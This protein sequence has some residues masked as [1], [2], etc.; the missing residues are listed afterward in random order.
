LDIHIDMPAYPV[1]KNL[2][3][4][5][6][7]DDFQ[8][9]GYK[10]Y[11]DPNYIPAVPPAYEE[12]APGFSQ[13]ARVYQDYS[14]LWNELLP[15]MDY[16]Q[17]VHHNPDQ[18]LDGEFVGMQASFA[19]PD[20]VGMLLA[21]Q[22][23]EE[24]IE[25]ENK[26]LPVR[27]RMSLEEL[28]QAHIQEQLMDT[29]KMNQ[30][31]AEAARLRA[32][33][34][35]EMEV[36]QYIQ[37]LTEQQM[38]MGNSQQHGL[39]QNAIL[40]YFGVATPEPATAADIPSAADIGAAIPPPPTAADIGAAVA[41]AL[42]PLLAGGAPLG[43]GGGGGGG[44]APPPG[45]G[46][47]GAPVGPPPVGGGGIPPPP[48]MPAGLLTGGGGPPG[49]GAPAGGMAALL[50]SI[51]GGRPTLRSVTSTS[52][53]TPA[54]A[55]SGGVASFAAQAAAALG[56]LR[57]ASNRTIAAPPATSTIAQQAAAAGLSGLRPTPPK[58][59]PPPPYDPLTDPSNPL[60]AAL[61]ARR[62]GI[63]P[64]TSPVSPTGLSFAPPTGPGISAVA[65][66]AGDSVGTSLAGPS[67]AA[68]SA[69]TTQVGARMD[70]NDV[71]TSLT[72]ITQSQIT[73]INKA[74]DVNKLPPYT[75]FRVSGTPNPEYAVR[76]PDGL[77]GG[78][79]KV[80]SLSN[81]LAWARG[82]E[83]LRPVSQYRKPNMGD[84]PTP[85][86]IDTKITEGYSR[87]KAGRKPKT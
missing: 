79:K 76:I 64:P 3:V 2:Q 65:P 51:A 71:R 41:A 15:Q 82:D 20:F 16:H 24:H 75:T 30:I 47:G 55:P 46:G 84:Q 44:G 61:A 83:N 50:A 69:A 1:L 74:S 54:P 80:V 10:G 17:F 28:I 38:F 62:G 86:F 5:G 22:M 57:P 48:P 42:A 70:A 34:A 78:N 31:K 40:Q 60:A 85:K 63:S 59:P 4:T 13:G 21:Q 27:D 26:T 73:N 43:G 81:F 14:P 53:S 36:R 68:A 25:H 6:K 49:G 8:L 67:S 77:L 66:P 58:S 45:G 33:G 87:G 35:S 72:T 11:R 23:Q 52:T 9:G 56:G 32:E 12:I 39:T 18:Q 29:K 19:D 7:P 37:E